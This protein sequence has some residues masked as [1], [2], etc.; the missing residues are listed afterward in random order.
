LPALQLNVDPDW[1]DA[2]TKRMYNQNWI[3]YD[4]DRVSIWAN[5]VDSQGSR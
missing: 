5:I 2:I 1:L 3:P 4:V